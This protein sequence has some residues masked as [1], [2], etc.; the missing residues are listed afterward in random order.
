MEK[1]QKATRITGPNPKDFLRAR[2]P[3]QFSDSLK[4]HESAIDRSVLEYHFESLNN[5]SQELQ[6]E[7]FVRKLCER[8][9]CP[10][11][12]PQTGPT[13]GGDGK[14]D[15]ETYPVSAQIAFFWGLNEA[16]EEERWAFGVSTQ[17]DWKAKC[18]KDVES[19]MSTG[20]GYARI[21]CVSSRYI[22]NSSRV[23]LQDE[24]STQYGVKVTILDRSWLLDKTL[25]PKNQHL[26]IDHLGL[27]GIVESKIQL[28]PF[29]ADKQ[30][31]LSEVER[32]ID[33]IENPGQLTISQVDL[34]SNRAILY[35]ELER[36]AYAVRQQFDI[37]A[38]TAKKFGTHRQRFDVLYDFTWAAYWWLEDTELFE[39]I[40]EKA[41]SVAQ[42]TDN[43]EVWEKVVTLFNLV[44]TT[45]RHG[46]C[47]LD[48]AAL[49]VTIREKL[50]AIASDDGMISGALQ[51]QTSLA[52]LDL[53]MA[54]T[55]EQLT[56]TFQSLAAIAESAK[57]L[58]GYPI[59]RLINLLEELD[60]AFG[61]FEVFEELIDKLIDD[62]SARQGERLIADKYLRRGALSLDKKDY[63][64]A[65]KCFGLSLYGL[66]NNESKK[67]VFGAL[68][69]LSHAYEKQGL[70]WAARGAAMMAAHIVSADAI[71]EQ[72]SS[73]KQAAVYHR[74]MWIEAQLGRLS[75]SLNWYYLSQLIAPMLDEAVWTED[76]LLSYQ[77]L[78]GKLFLNGRFSD[79]EK[80]AWLPDKLNQM[81]LYLS[82]D[83]LLICLGHEDKAG[84]EGEPIDFEF[85]NLWRSTDMGAPIAALDLYT[86]RW[87]TIESHILGCKVSVTFPVKSPCV[88]LAQ[89]LLAVLESFCAPMMS[90]HMVA[91]LPRV[92]IDISLDDDDEMVLQHTFDASAQVT[93]A[94]ILCSMFSIARLEDEQRDT[95]QRF[96]TEFCLQFVTVICPQIS[97]SQLEEMLRDD[98]A[99]ERSVMFNC[100]LSL[101]GFIMGHDTSPS[102]E[103]HQKPPFER[104]EPT[105]KM[106]WFEHYNIE[107]LDLRPKADACEQLPKHPFQFSNLKH[108]DLKIE[109]IIQEGLWNQAGWRAIGFMGGGGMLPG[110]MFGFENAVVGS[111]IFDNIASAIGKKDPHNKL[112]I[113][114]IR[115]VSRA[116]L[117]HYRVVVTSNIQNDASDLSGM[118]TVLSRMITMTPE[119]SENLERF[120]LDYNAADK[121]VIATASAQ[122][123]PVIH[124]ITSGVKVKYAWEIDE[125]DPDISSIHPDDD[126]YIPEGMENPPISRALAMIQS[127][128]DSGG[129][130]S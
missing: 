14:T 25:E 68:Y 110:L 116:N 11:L 94:H 31:Q 105:R 61:E 104:Y 93:T 19:I 96:Y 95:I 112:R 5:R 36:D 126:V 26:A 45:H 24:L 53:L 7:T 69:M 103:S 66:Y 101:E 42:D 15:T 111:K 9:I 58:I 22:K 130:R 59:A 102:I 27:T 32:Q 91:T 77:C 88:Q 122:G 84:P 40:F 90:S 125:N 13:A 127:M 39:E 100:N 20:R 67:E 57:K 124:V 99:L 81:G 109:S 51:A 113:V 119:S 41:L 52:L 64:R 121:F 129:Q 108:R 128:R 107:P 120:L 80:L 55:E 86:E 16:P 8:E 23:A 2:R 92:N 114:L 28:G 46:T 44:V 76:Q 74:L 18:V 38:R 3:E 62:A 83:A 29:D 56:A 87:T 78:I 115:G 37:A 35:K 89:Q 118:H 98:K 4:L 123:R 30:I 33:Q 10:N 117:G 17:K 75:Q 47:T 106:T 97:W 82:A 65:I 79:I 1:Q 60:V 73:P 70:L 21:F 50:N 63:Y 49:E 72:R 6:F 34:Y 43:V 71:K 85:I 12:V 54:R 48:V